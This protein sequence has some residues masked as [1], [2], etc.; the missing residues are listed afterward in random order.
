MLDRI[1]D[2]ICYNPWEMDADTYYRD[3]RIE[4]M[5]EDEEYEE[6]VQR[7]LDEIDVDEEEDKRAWMLTNEE[8][9]TLWLPDI[10]HQKNRLGFYGYQ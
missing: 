8:I 3:R 6:H 7:L 4:E 2:E 1:T 10:V 5:R 9:E